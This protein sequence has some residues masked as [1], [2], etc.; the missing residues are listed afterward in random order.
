[1][2][3]RVLSA[4]ALGRTG[5]SDWLIQRVSALIM[6]AFTAFLIGYYL[7]HAPLDYDHWHALFSCMLMKVFT[8][9]TLLALLGHAWV[10]MWTILTD[11][12]K[13]PYTRGSLQILII[14]AF[15]ACLVWGIH[16]LWA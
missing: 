5:V 10:G 14:L 9:L 8:L 3:K 11:Y 7:A 1:M 13:C 4:T 16:I 6:L 12:I 2:V 15:F